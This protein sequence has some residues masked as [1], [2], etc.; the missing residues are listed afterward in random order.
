MGQKDSYVGDEAQSKRGIL[1]LKYPIEHGIVTNWDDMEKIWLSNLFVDPSAGARRVT[2]DL[3]W[4]EPQFDLLLSR[5]YGVWAVAN[6]PADLDAVVSA[7][8]SW[9]GISWVGGSQHLASS[10]DSSLSLPYHGNN[11]SAAHVLDQTWEETFA[12]QVSVVVLKVFLAGSHHF[13]GCH[14]EAFIFESLDDLAN[15]STLYSVWFDSNEGSFVGHFC[16][17]HIRFGRIQWEGCSARGIYH[18]R[19][20][21]LT[22]SGDIDGLREFSGK[23]VQLVAS[24]TSKNTSLHNSSLRTSHADKLNLFTLNLLRVRTLANSDHF[25]GETD[26]VSIGFNHVHLFSRRI[27]LLLLSQ[28]LAKVFINL[29]G[30]YHFLNTSALFLGDLGCFPLGKTLA[31]AILQHESKSSQS[32]LRQNTL[33]ASLQVRALFAIKITTETSSLISEDQMVGVDH[34]SFTISKNLNTILGRVDRVY[35]ILKLGNIRFLNFLLLLLLK[36]LFFLLFTIDLDNSLGYTRISGLLGD[37]NFILLTINN[38]LDNLLLLGVLGGDNNS[39]SGGLFSKD[40][41]FTVVNSIVVILTIKGL[42][43]AGLNIAGRRH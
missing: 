26:L 28:L 21:K 30:L 6:V 5:V 15:E 36:R 18:Q 38:Q 14:F 32:G 34:H 31:L 27:S 43:I 39:G 11:W 33:S 7:D 13:H 25:L 8:G 3:L 42:D 16:L 12:F 2:A 24:I 29:G 19:E 23:V 9:E 41:M 22:L 4:F 17:G 20:H 40:N 10:F 35:S 1:T 37:F